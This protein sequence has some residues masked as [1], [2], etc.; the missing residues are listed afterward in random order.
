M[1]INTRGIV[2]SK[3]IQ[4]LMDKEVNRKEFLAHLG[5]GALAIIG[6]SGLL[7][8]LGEIGRPARPQGY[9]SSSYGGGSAKK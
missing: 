4:D 9:G 2:S 1:T 6:V 7:K 5:A 8:N 3:L